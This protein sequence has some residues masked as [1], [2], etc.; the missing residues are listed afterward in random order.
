MKI[1]YAITVCDEF[2]ELQ[3][4]INCLLN[5]IDLSRH[6]IVVLCDLTKTTDTIIEYCNSH[7]NYRN[8]KFFTDNFA[9]HFSEWKNKLKSLCS[10][11]YIFQ[12]DA[13]ETPS[14]FLLDN[15][16]T[17]LQE[18]S[19][20]ELFWIPRENYVRGLTEEHITKW[21]W[22]LDSLNRINFPDYQARLFK[23]LPHIHWQNKVHEII[24][25]CTAQATLPAEAKFCLIHSKDINRQEKQNDFYNILMKK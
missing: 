6:E 5:K 15:L 12:I 25:G 22:N 2:T 8:I 13:D 24:V 14:N 1:S 20:I 7:Q 3:N 16:E 11:D 9:G 23:N 17:I 18:N 4:L 19:S 21:K 10:G